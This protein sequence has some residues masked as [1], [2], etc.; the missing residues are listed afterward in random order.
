M[1]VMS[2]SAQKNKDFVDRLKADYPQFLFKKGVQ[3]HWSP[4]TRTITYN[5]S[6]QWQ[7]LANSLL[8]ELAHAVLGHSTY[9]SDVELLKLEAQAWEL[10]TKIGRKYK[11]Y[12]DDNHIQNCLD[13]YRDWLHRRSSCPIC[14]THVVQKDQKSYQCFNCQT[15]WQVSSGRFVRAYRKTT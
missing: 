11:V 10:A 3:E 12:I 4:Q 5:P 15:V 8:H 13:T 14:S 2:S 9:G 6:R 7:E 1:V